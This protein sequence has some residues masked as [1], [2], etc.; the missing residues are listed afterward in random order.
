MPQGDLTV[1]VG[2]LGIDED[3]A[4]GSARGVHKEQIINIKY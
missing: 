3:L 2:L 1:C 4:S